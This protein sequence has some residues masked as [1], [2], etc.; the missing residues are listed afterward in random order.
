M[1]NA[2]SYFLP[3]LAC[4]PHEIRHITQ[5]T[6]RPLIQP[7]DMHNAYKYTVAPAPKKSTIAARHQTNET[8]RRIEPAKSSGTRR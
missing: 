2:S 4:Y 6:T 8:S 7:R 5:H 1:N 3:P